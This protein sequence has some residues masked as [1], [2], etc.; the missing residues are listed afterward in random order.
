MKTR[1]EVNFEYKW[2][3]IKFPECLAIPPDDTQSLK[4]EEL[5]VYPEALN[6]ITWFGG[7]WP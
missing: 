6:Q 4:D 5:V 7:K 3:A 1:Q 2:R